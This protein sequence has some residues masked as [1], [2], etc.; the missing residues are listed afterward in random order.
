M[1]AAWTSE[2]LV[3]YHETTRHHNPEDLGLKSELVSQ[4]NILLSSLHLEYVERIQLWPSLELFL[5]S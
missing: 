5:Q 2:T 4:L 3:S 1:E